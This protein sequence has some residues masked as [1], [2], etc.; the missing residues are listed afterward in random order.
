[1]LTVSEDSAS[2]CACLESNRSLNEQNTK[3]KSDLKKLQE[4]NKELSEQLLVL[5]YD[6]SKNQEIHIQLEIF[7]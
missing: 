3:M 1:M 5:R 2:T 7:R 6:Q 4:E